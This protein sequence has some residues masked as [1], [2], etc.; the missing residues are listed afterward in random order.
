MTRFRWGLASDVGRSRSVNQD[1]ALA[2]EGLFAVA[3][4]MG[5]HRGGEVASDVAV[6]MLRD[7]APLLTSDDL[8]GAIHVANDAILDQSNDDETLRGMGTTLC[9]LALV[10]ADGE[11]RLAIAN[12][13]DSRVYLFAQGELEQMTDDHS[14]V[15]ALVREG[16]ITQ[17][18]AEEHPQ[19]NI[20]T[21]ALGIDYMVSVDAWEVMPYVGDRWVLC[22]DGLFNEVSIDQ[23]AAVLRRLEDPDEA[24]RELVRLANEGGGRDN[25]TV[26]IVDVV[27]EP[28][29]AVI[30]P[31]GDAGI[32]P[33][34]VAG[35]ALDAP[36]ADEVGPLTR[37]RRRNRD[38]GAPRFTWRVALFLFSMLLVAAIAIG[39][40]AFWGGDGDDDEPPPDRVTT[41]VDP[42]ATTT[43]S[44]TTSTTSTTVAPT[45]TTATTAVTPASP[46][47]LAGG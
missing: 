39:A 7:R 47:T 6:R 28:G 29:H 26:L 12:V 46:T 13:G 41:T 10:D 21:R 37:A 33:A 8:I 17:E 16:R 42:D 31:N 11:P 36:G 4:G 22:S 38:A 24:A 34:A 44:S 45:A 27:D 14:L 15:A 19:R 1:N 25:I 40:I 35:A 9:V 18:E 5:G 3:D 43:S 30:S 32:A 2:I 23:M 20:L